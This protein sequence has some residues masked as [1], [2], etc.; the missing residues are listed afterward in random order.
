MPL[1]PLDISLLPLPLELM[2]NWR[3]VRRCSVLNMLCH[4]KRSKLKFN[5]VVERWGFPRGVSAFGTAH[6]AEASQ[7]A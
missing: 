6:S 5:D 7:L 1:L 2:K 4:R 3:S